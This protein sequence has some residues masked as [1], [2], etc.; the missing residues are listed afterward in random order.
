MLREIAGALYYSESATGDDGR[1]GAVVTAP[2]L[3]TGTYFIRVLPKPDVVLSERFSL[4]VQ[5]GTN[6]VI[7]ADHAIISDIPTLGYGIKSARGVIV[8]LT[9]VR[10]D[11]TI[12]GGHIELSFPTELGKRYQAQYKDYLNDLMWADLGPVVTGL[13]IRMVISDDAIQKQRFYRIVDSE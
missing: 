3:K 13:G 6:V 5:A 10:L 9:P 11:I 4:D 8:P 2:V 12:A 1:P 7:L